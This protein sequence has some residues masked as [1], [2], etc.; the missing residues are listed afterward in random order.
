MIPRE[1][2]DACFW[3]AICNALNVTIIRSSTTT[4]RPTTTESS[5][6][7]SASSLAEVTYKDDKG[8]DQKVQLYVERA[9]GDAPFESV[10]QRGVKLRSGPRMLDQIEQLEEYA[11]PDQ[12]MRACRQMPWREQDCFRFTVGVNVYGRT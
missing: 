5:A 8:A 6:F 11:E 10:F 7:V 9:A 4:C 12:R 1:I 2:S 3:D